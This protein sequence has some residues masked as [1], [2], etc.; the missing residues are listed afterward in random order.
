MHTPYFERF[1]YPK[2]LRLGLGE[3]WPESE[4]AEASTELKNEGWIVHATMKS[5]YERWLEG[6]VAILAS[7]SSRKRRTN[8]IPV[9]LG[10]TEYGRNQTRIK[11]IHK[12]N[13]TYKLYKRALKNELTEAE[14]STL[15]R[16]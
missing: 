7:G 9:T 8:K 6:S 12:M 11:R 10:F 16:G 15:L 5:E 4:S 13:G 1:A 3:L 2:A 14:L